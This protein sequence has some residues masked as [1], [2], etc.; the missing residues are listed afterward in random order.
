MKANFPK[1]NFY[2]NA[3]YPD[4]DALE[5]LCVSFQEEFKS[6][7]L[8]HQTWPT[9]DGVFYS[10]G[11]LAGLLKTL[12][13]V[14]D[15][16]R[17]GHSKVLDV[18]CGEGRLM[19]VL[20]ELGFD[21]TGV[22]AHVFEGLNIEAEPRG[23]LLEQYFSEKGINVKLVDIE[24]EALPFPSN[25]FDLVTFIETIEHLHNSPKPILQE[26]ARVLRGGG[27]LLLVCPNYAAL[28]KRILALLGASNHWDLKAYYNF[29]CVSHPSM[30][31]IGHVREFTLSEVEQMLRWEDFRIVFSQ[32]CALPVKMPSRLKQ[33]I[34]Q[35]LDFLFRFGRTLQPNI[36]VVAQK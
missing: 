21:A 3:E 11:Y 18:G 13:L 30:D 24:K 23:P 25:H 12:G 22:D 34:H 6:R 16:C 33:S 1:E 10:G 36:F 15:Q 8:L 7:K 35:V 2:F 29:E 4:K 19:L 28:S 26:I 5:H 31:F 27:Y 20:K 14:P 9:T 17:G 32:T